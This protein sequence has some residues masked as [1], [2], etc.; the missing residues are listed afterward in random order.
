LQIWQDIDNNTNPPQAEVLDKPVSV[1]VWRKAHAP[2][3][4]SLSA[5]EAAAVSLIRRGCE[6]EHLGSTLVGRFPNDDVATLFGELLRRWIDDEFLL[7]NEHHRLT[8]NFS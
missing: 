4:R 6:L 1:L 2:H 7:R 5:F 8:S 3:F